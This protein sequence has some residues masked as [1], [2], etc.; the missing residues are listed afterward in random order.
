MEIKYD[1]LVGVAEETKLFV[2]HLHGA[3]VHDCHIFHEHLQLAG[4]ELYLGVGHADG[5]EGICLS[6]ELLLCVFEILNFIGQV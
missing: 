4:I 3:M 2:G 6:S 1:N 5:L